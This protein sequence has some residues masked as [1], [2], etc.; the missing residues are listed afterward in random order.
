MPTRAMLGILT[1]MLA[2]VYFGSIRPEDASFASEAAYRMILHD[3]NS[4]TPME[5]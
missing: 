2:I 3:P 4:E 5:A 1:Y